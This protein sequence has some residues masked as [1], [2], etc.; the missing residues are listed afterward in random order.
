MVDHG[1][2][3][4]V[5]GA[6]T[7]DRP[8]L[9]GHKFSRQ[10]VLAGA[11]FPVPPLVC[12]PAT[13]FDAVVG[14]VVRA[15]LAEPME[16]TDRA[17]AL[18]RRIVELGV[19]EALRASLAER[20]DSVAGSDGLLAVRAC[21]VAR[22]GAGSFIEDSGEDSA[23]DPFAGLSDSFLYVGR[24]ELADRVAACWASAFNPEAVLYRAHRGLDPFAARIAVGVQRMV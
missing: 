17:Q 18:R 16:A 14:P 1:S 2:E 20:F 15:S 23:S 3:W 19:P 9:F 7:A 6:S 22:A 12:V 21:V 10:A 11:G 4:L 8:D 24:D 5:D 13:V